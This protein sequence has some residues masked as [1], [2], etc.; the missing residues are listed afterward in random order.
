MS[1]SYQEIRSRA[2]HFAHEWASASRER[3][4]AQT[5]WNEFF[6]IFGISR[7]RVAS[8]EVPVELLGDRRGSIDLFW[9]GLLIVEHKSRNA[10]LDRAYAQAIDYFPGIEEE[11]L[12]RYVLVSDFARFCQRSS[13]NV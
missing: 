6:Y 13:G 7:R 10:N 4:E 11:K 8:F 2:Q 3:A 9:P 12:P 5:F 1:L